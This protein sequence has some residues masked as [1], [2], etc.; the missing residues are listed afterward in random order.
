MVRVGDYEKLMSEAYDRIKRALESKPEFYEELYLPE[1]EKEY[2][3]L[4]KKVGGW[5]KIPYGFLPYFSAE[6]FNFE[7]S[8]GIV[9]LG[10]K[11]THKEYTMTGAKS[12]FGKYVRRN[13]KNLETWEK[14]NYNYISMLLGKEERGKIIERVKKEK[15]NK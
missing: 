7:I 12:I 2:R 14:A 11:K 9:Y 3:N 4:A 10:D 5:K 1:N 15:R 8:D 13:F 6:T